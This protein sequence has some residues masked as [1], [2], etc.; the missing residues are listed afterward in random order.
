MVA[1]VS[2]ISCGD[3]HSAA[4]TVQDRLILWGDCAM[5]G[6]GGGD[7]GTAGSA[8]GGSGEDAGEPRKFDATPFL[9]GVPKLVR[10]LTN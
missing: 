10:K 3:Y 5:E 4:L 1:A 7:R 8:G 6:G 9:G 2:S